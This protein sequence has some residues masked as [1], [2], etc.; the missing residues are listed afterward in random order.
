MP[1]SKN[2]IDPNQRKKVAIAVPITNRPNL[3][4]DEQISL[5][6]LLHF[7]GGYDIYF[8]APEGLDIHHP[9]IENKYFSHKYFGSGAAHSKLLLSTTFYEA[10]IDYEYLLLCHLDTLVF[11]DQLNQWCDEDY[12]YIAPPWIVH[13]DAP[14]AGLPEYEGKIGNGGF[15]LRKIDSFLKVINSNVYFRDPEDFWKVS[16]KGKS[17]LWKF[18]NQPRRLMYRIPRFNNA[19]IEISRKIGIEDVFWANRAPHYYPEFKLAP[20]EVALKFAFECLPRYCYELNGN[21][22]PFGCHAWQAYD[23]AFWEP[24]LLRAPENADDSENRLAL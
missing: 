1:D 21:Q 13:E 9:Q 4:P 23:K 19:Q 20:I 6:H 18:L 12:D 11:S 5:N 22:L 15:S 8:I 14:Y 16:C 7:L 24:F 17:S 10:F 3:T 2:D